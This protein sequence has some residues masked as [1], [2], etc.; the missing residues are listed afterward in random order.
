MEN[1]MSKGSKPK[2]A[3]SKPMPGKG[4]PGKPC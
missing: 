1:T 4:K 3:P 2:R